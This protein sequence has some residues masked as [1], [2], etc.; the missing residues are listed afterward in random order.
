MCITTI[1][2]GDLCD[3]TGLVGVSAKWSYVTASPSHH[4]QAI[5]IL[6]PLL[7]MHVGQP[8]IPLFKIRL[9]YLSR[10]LF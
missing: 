9:I 1:V 4:D 5:S 8:Y 10:L 7:F 6:S 3:N 2:L